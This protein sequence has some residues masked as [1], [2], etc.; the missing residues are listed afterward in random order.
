MEENMRIL[1][2]TVHEYPHSG[3]L[4][5][6]VTTLKSGLE[7]LGHDVDIMSFHDIPYFKQILYAQGPSFL[8]NRFSRGRG[9]IFGRNARKQLLQTAIG[10][11]KDQYDIINSQ[12][13]YATFASVASGVPTVSTVHGYLSYEAVSKG[14]IREGSK[15]ASYLQK[16]EIDSFQ[17]TKQ[18]ITVDQRIKTYVKQIS[19]IDAEAIRNFIDVDAFKPA[20][21]NKQELREKL[22]IPA[23]AKVLFVPRRLTKKNGVIYPVLALQEILDIHPEALLIY[24]GNGE[25]QYEIERITKKLKI[26]SSVRMLGAIPHEEIINYYTISDVVLVPSVHSAGV[27]EATSISAL[28]AMGSCVPVVAG[29]VG[30]LKEIVIHN[31][32][33]LLVEQKDVEALS[34]AVNK[35][36]SDKDFALRIAKNARTKIEESYSHL[37]AA[38]KYAAIYEEV[39]KR[40]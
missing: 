5:T 12:D 3:G 11:V 4:S 24:A 25:E 8:L 26:S 1:F 15:E 32:N 37:A 17:M 19:G 34:K 23:D 40:G 27:E 30:G 10:K 35:L 6:H 38:K 36:L 20:F 22:A 7:A 33:G 39:L 2:T 28:E 16:K 13:I 14:T 29:A 21:E 9:T 31:E 18:V